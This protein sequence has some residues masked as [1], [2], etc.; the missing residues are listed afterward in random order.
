[1]SKVKIGWS[2]IDITPKKGVKIG[3][4]GQFFERITDEVE[5]PLKIVSMAIE[6]G[7]D[8][9]IFA[10][11]DLVSVANNLCDLVK[12]NLKDKLPISPD[13]VIISAIHTHTSYTYTRK[14][15]LA[16]KL[17]GTMQTFAN[18]LQQVLPPDMAYEPLVSGEECM[19]DEDALAFLVEKI[20]ESVIQAWNNRKPAFYQNAFGRAVVGMNRRVCYDDGSAKMWGDTNLA[21]FDALE[22]GNDSGIELIYTFDE[23]KELTGVVANIACPA[24]V[25]E[26]RSYISSDYWGKVRENLEKKFGRKIF[27]LGLC[28][29]AG[30]QCPRDMIR[31]V[32][33]ETPIDDP[34]IKRE[35]YF[36]RR[37]DPSMFDVSGLK[38]VGKR[39]SNEII[40][41]F[42]EL[43]D[44]YKDEGLL[45][46]ETIEL[47]LP[48]RRVTISDYNNAIEAIDRFIEKN[49]GRKVSFE[50][51]AAMHVHSG[52][53]A[54]YKEQQVI[55]TIEIEVHFLRFGDVAFAT[56][57]FELF[58]DYGNQIR[59]R[60]KAKQTFLIQLCCGTAGYLP[61][62]KAQEGSHYSAYVSS[63]TT[64]YKGGDIL[65]R[66]TLEHINDMFKA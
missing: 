64:D 55:D 11:C 12:E 43:G 51:S 32:N 50:D 14:G 23:N 48:L 38:L 6:S 27:V 15:A 34:N 19:S 30:D 42:E 24:Q 22:A 57:P 26:H 47:S 21:N 17:K 41:V 33:P 56:N 60:S 5:S 54:R 8:Q 10:A 29:A 66:T 53:I 62:K 18:Y 4:A 49:R 59:A 20:S 1:M 58:L 46:H 9:V 35:K 63:G 65:V 45:I 52:T 13:K 3:L 39:I 25:V 40:N 7:N 16:K 28:S 37:A 61:T 31:W 36:E 2:E 44:D